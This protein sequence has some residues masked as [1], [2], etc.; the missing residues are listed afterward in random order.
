MPC[1]KIIQL[2]I[3][4]KLFIVACLADEEDDCDA[5]AVNGECVT[6]MEWMLLNCQQTCCCDTRDT[7]N[8]LGNDTE[9]DIWASAG[10][11]S[12]NPAWMGINCEKS[13]GPYICEVLPFPTRS[14]ELVPIEGINVIPLIFLSA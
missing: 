12:N 5:R 2:N 13:C 11:C 10:E 6:N 7:I 4:L 3:Y 8:A 14:P 9:C 1:N